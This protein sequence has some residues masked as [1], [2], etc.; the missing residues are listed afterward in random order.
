MI[1]IYLPDKCDVFVANLQTF[2]LSIN[3]SGY[4]EKLTDNHLVQKL[5]YM[6]KTA[7]SSENLSPLQ[8]V[9]NV[10]IARLVQQVAFYFDGDSGNQIRDPDSACC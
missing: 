7:I 10:L 8:Q 1:Q 6:M 9:Q 5:E 2:E 3:L 4:I